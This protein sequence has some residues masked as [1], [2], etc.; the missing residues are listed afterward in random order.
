MIFWEIIKLSFLVKYIKKNKLKKYTSDYKKT[1]QIPWYHAKNF[2][3]K[4]ETFDKNTS[5]YDRLLEI[6]NIKKLHYCLYKNIDT[7]NNFFLNHNKKIY[8]IKHKGFFDFDKNAKD[9]Y[10][11]LNPWAF[12]RVK[13]EAITLRAS[14]ESILPAIQRGI[15]GYNDCNDGSEEIILEFC[16]QYPSFIPKKYPYKIQIE[17]PQSEENKLYTYYNWV[18]SFIP[19]GEW[20]IKIDVDHIYDAKKL[21]E[22]F[23]IP[24]NDNDVLS[25]AR[26]DFVVFD[27]EIFI[28]KGSN[29]KLLKDVT[30]HWLLK[31]DQDIIWREVLIDGDS[32]NWKEINTKEKDR[33]QNLKSFEI[34]K[35]PHKKFLRTQLTNYHFPYAK[36]WRQI[37]YK[38]TN[39]TLIKLEDFTKNYYHEFKDKISLDMLDKN[40]ILTI[41]NGF[42]NQTQT[43]YNFKNINFYIKKIYKITNKYSIDKAAQ[44]KTNQIQTLSQTMQNTN[45][46]TKY[47][48]A[49]IR[50]QN[51]LSYKLGQALIINSKSVLGFLFLPFIILSIVIS[52]KQEQK[53]YKIKIKKNPNLALLPL[54]AYPD[55]QKAIKEKECFT[56][57]LG[58]AL[59]KANKTWYKGGYIRFI[60]EVGKLKKKF[61]KK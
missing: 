7:L 58:E 15:I 52:H 46:Q 60:F 47:K 59:I 43:N 8:G 26:V 17:N 35:L 12:I 37:D 29:G 33:Y 45:L 57:K 56:Y 41:Y 20:L 1:Y 4:K 49:K 3:D 22:S 53:A 34:L 55:Y 21:Y 14:L 6:Y 54:E 28:I 23:Y 61:K 44:G 50:I 30:D 11:P 25:I 27:N 32:F 31:K 36:K 2:I 16:K 39:L 19:Q 42:F 9:K 13:N 51:Q 18:A 40:K 5:V 24:K 10:S 38:N 48:T